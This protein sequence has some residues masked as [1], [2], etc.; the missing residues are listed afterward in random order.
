MSASTI[1]F[2]QLEVRGCA[3]ELWLNGAPLIRL[4]AENTPIENAAAGM[5]VVPGTNR[6]DVLVEPGSTPSTA[7]TENRQMPFRPMRA[8]GRL[9]RFREG[10]PGLVENGELLGEA[11]L[12]WEGGRPERRAFPAEVGVQIEMYGGHG[13]WA[14][15]DGPV[16][17][18]DAAL[19]AEVDALLDDLERAVRAGDADRVW[20]L[21]ELQLHD[22]LRAFPALTEA[23]MRD[24]LAALLEHAKKSGDPVVPRDRDAHDF[25]L[26]AGGRML[27]LVDRDWSTSF[28]VRDPDGSATPYRILLARVDGRLRVMR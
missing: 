16:L 3:A 2:A 4:G 8:V 17:T 28:K 6:L 5:L 25:R 13:R 1:V 9:I 11:S 18:L 20:R 21:T 23:A 24:E 22:A 14:W 27:E 7:R 10:E 15:Q 26:V 19:R 12:L